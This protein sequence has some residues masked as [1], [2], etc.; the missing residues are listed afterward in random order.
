MEPPIEEV[1]A[2]LAD[3]R[4]RCDDALRELTA[5]FDGA[6]IDDLRVPSAAVEAALDQIDP[7]FIIT[8]RAGLED[9]PEL[10]RTFRDKKDDCVKV[11]MRPGAH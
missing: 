6:E 5:R 9:A 2:L 3:V 8:H 10:Y 1:R 11:V 4:E 7:A